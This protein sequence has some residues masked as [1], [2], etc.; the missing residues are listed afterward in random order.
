MI[1]LL[2]TLAHAE[3]CAA[4]HVEEA[5]AHEGSR[6]QVSWTNA[7]FREGFLAEPR[8]FC[9]DCH[10]P[11]P[12]QAAEIRANRAWYLSGGGREGDNVVARLPEPAAEE[13]I[14][15]EACHVRDGAVVVSRPVRAPHAVVVDSTLATSEACRGCHEFAF[16]SFIGGEQHQLDLLMQSTWSEWAAWVAG[17][18][19]AE[20]QGCHMPD[21]DHAMHGAHD[22]R[23]LRRSVDIDVVATPAG[24][25]FTLGS[26]DVGHSLPTGDLFRHLTLEAWRDERWEVLAWIGRR[27][28]VDADGETVLLSDTSIRPGEPLVVDAPAA[29][30]RLVYH[31]GSE[32]D[33]ARARLA[34]GELTVTLAEGR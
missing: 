25:R 12:E 16:E 4:C 32:V 20:C 7:V 13:G 24:L 33:E 5:R 31:Y 9:I 23:L 10:A 15:C 34:P 8:A 19:D 28:G 18:G 1:P 21:G 11:L 6:H 22:L 17:G 26:V 14:T 27:Y 30:W 29:P 2:A 3:P